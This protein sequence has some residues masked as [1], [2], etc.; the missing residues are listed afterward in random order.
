M[1]NGISGVSADRPDGALLE[2]A[3]E[4][5]L[6]PGRHLA[7]LVEEE[8]PARGLQEEPSPRLAGVGEGALHVT[9]KLAL[10]ELL[11]HRRAVDRD[12]R[13]AERALRA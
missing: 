9:E 13:P 10:E 2:R 5:G 4:L 11:G 8:R 6:H 7:D 3:Q 1:S 12:E